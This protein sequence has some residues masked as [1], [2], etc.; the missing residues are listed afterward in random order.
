MART[1]RWPVVCMTYSLHSYTD[2]YCKSAH[3]ESLHTIIGSASVST[4]RIIYLSFDTKLT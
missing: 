4:T 3:L 1:T 2:K